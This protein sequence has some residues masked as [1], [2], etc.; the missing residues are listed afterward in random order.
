MSYISYLVGF[1][2]LP[3]YSCKDLVLYL[4]AFDAY[5]WPHSYTSK[6][7]YDLL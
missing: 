7:C 1:P 2:N 4:L 6:L 5:E 3:A